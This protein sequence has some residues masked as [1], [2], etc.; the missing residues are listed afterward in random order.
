MKVLFVCT[1]NICRSPT[2]EGVFRR[3]VEAAGLGHAIE[4]DSCGLYDFHVG[5][6]PD[7]RAQRAARRR[8]FE[9]S[10]LRG[11]KLHR[12]D[13][14]AFDLV[15]AMDRDHHRTLLRLCPRARRD[16]VRYFLDFAPELGRRSVPDPFFG[17]E[18]DFEA[19]LDL[20]EAGA[21][22]LLTALR[23]SRL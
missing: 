14:E 9:L 18:A 15:L 13:F 19:A 1:G 11:R 8:G 10:D 5:Q 6:P 12:R 17:D 21:R 3:L 2:A 16:R 4:A 7:S 23:R 22:G 20:I